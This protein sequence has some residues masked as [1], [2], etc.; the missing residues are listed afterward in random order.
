M[1]QEIV[2]DKMELIQ[3]SEEDEKIAVIEELVTVYDKVNKEDER[4]K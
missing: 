3:E 1:K 2:V 4:I